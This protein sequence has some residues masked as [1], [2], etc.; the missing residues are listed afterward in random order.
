M[1]RLASRPSSTARLIATR[2]DLTANACDSTRNKSSS[3]SEAL[4]GTSRSRYFSSQTNSTKTPKVKGPLANEHLI[5]HLIQK[6]NAISADDVDVRLVVSSKKGGTTTSLVSLMNAI[7]ICTDLGVDL[8]GV[9]IEQSP[10]VIKAQNIDKLVYQ[11]EKR[12]TSKS[13]SKPTKEFQFR[14]CIA[15]NDFARKADSIVKYL[16]KGHNC[17]VLIRANGMARRNDPN[18]INT[19]VERLKA[20]VSDFALP[21]AIKPNEDNSQAT[22]FL[23]AT[24]KKG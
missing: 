23:Q 7:K 18:C 20:S 22:V 11:A 10:P 2:F 17:Q 4:D 1:L 15:A 5:T 13:G 21:G 19:M 12:A 24:S 14:A 8:V 6:Q 9:N 3:L 16:Q